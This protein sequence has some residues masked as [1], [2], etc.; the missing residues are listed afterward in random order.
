MSISSIG[1]EEIR[2]AAEVHAELAPEYRDAVVESF[3]DRVN[4]EIDERVDRRLAVLQQPAAP[5]PRPRSMALAITSMALGIPLTAVV[6]GAANGGSQ[7]IELIVIWLAIAVINVAYALGH[8]PA[9][10]RR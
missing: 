6:T 3:L 8:R 5:E 4:K 9:P 10:R 2:A 1:P 7:T